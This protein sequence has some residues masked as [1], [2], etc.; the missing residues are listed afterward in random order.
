S[1]SSP[2]MPIFQDP[3]R[4]LNPRWPIWRSVVEPITR[5]R[6]IFNRTELREQAHQILQSVG[7]GHLD[8]DARPAELSVG[9]CQRVAIARALAAEPSLLIADEPTSALDAAASA[10]VM[11]LMDQVAQRGTAIVMVSHNRKMLESLCD[12][13]L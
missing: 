6:W 12:R 9:Q 11:Q 8:I 3:T 7:L 2:V 5:G 13:V 1:T 10:R 4:S